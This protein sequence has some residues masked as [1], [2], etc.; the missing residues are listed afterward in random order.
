M[1]NVWDELYRVQR[2]LRAEAIAETTAERQRRL[3]A[4]TSVEHARLPTG[5]ELRQRRMNARV[6]QSEVA[7]MLGTYQT[8]ISRLENHP[9]RSPSERLLVRELD[10]LLPPTPCPQHATVT[11]KRRQ[12]IEQHIR[13]WAAQEPENVARQIVALD[14][15][16]RLKLTS[17]LAFLGRATVNRS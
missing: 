8:I 16:G 1:T 5:R 15:L 7:E 11:P 4:E 9:P 14:M 3:R 17:P 6:S 13:E 10:E 12:E 2:R